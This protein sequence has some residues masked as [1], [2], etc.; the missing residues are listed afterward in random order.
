[1]SKWSQ[2]Q[3]TRCNVSEIERK[4][5]KMHTSP[6]YIPKKKW[7][8]PLTKISSTNPPPISVTTL[9]SK[10]TPSFCHKWQR[11]KVS[12]R[13]LVD[14]GRASI[15]ILIIIVVIGVIIVLGCLVV[16]GCLRRRRGRLHKDTKAN[17]P[18]G[19]TAGM[20]V[21][22]T[23]LI[24]DIV[25]ASI[26]ALKLHHNRIKSHTTRRRKGSGG[27]WSWRSGRSCR[28]ER[29]CTSLC[30]TV[31]ASM[32]HM[33]WKWSETGKGTE[34]WRKILVIVEGKMSL[35][36]VTKS[37][38]ISMMER[39]KW[40]EKSIVRCSKRESKNRAWGSVIEL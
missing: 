5:K 34:K 19:N 6:H 21:H 24:T 12:S 33:T 28:L 20:G 35:S 30:L 39:I 8:L 9:I 22:L 17:L 11:V 18:S 29:N 36:R 40:E 10:T 23:Q 32:A 14:T 37:L 31:V 2:N 15:S 3:Y 1:M 4:E 38:Y 7:T 27:G 26:H 16:L 13:H 25:K